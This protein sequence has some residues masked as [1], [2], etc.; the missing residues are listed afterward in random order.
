MVAMQVYR[1]T[2]ELLDQRAKSLPDKFV[3]WYTN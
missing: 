1:C 3:P 2:A